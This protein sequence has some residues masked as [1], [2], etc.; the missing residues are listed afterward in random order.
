MSRMSVTSRDKEMS[1]MPTRY[2][3]SKLTG[4]VNRREQCESPT[5]PR[6]KQHLMGLNSVYVERADI[7]LF[8]MLHIHTAR[9]NK[10]VF[11]SIVTLIDI[12]LMS[13]F[14]SGYIQH[15]LLTAIF[16]V[17]SLFFIVSWLAFSCQLVSEYVS[18]YEETPWSIVAKM[19]MHMSTSTD[20][21][22]KVISTIFGI[23]W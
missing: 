16:Y 23:L 21:N 22:L 7:Y 14:F 5:L 4:L 9:D 19:Y 6:L 3:Q 2:R 1:G 15:F 8:C 11:H 17:H 10:V 13:H 20:E 18:S 12:G